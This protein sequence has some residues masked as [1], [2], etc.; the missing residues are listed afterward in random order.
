[1]METIQQG[2][3][4][5]GKRWAML[6]ALVSGLLFPLASILIITVLEQVLFTF[7]NIFRIHLEH[8]ELF[9]LY[10]LPLILAYIVHLFYA[11]L[12]KKQEYFQHIIRRKDETINRNAQFAEEIGKGYY[13]VNIIPDGDEDVLGKSLLAM[14]ENLLAKDRKESLHNWISEG[15]DL[16]SNILRIYNKLEEIGDHLLEHLTKY[17]DAVQGAIYLYHEEEDSLIS[18]SAYAYQHKNNPGQKFKVGYGLIG[19]CAYERKYIYR[20]EIPDDYF[21]ISSGLLG[22]KKP[23]SLLI[24][25]LITEDMLQGVVEM[26]FLKP[27]IPEQTIELMKELGEIIA[28]AILNLRINQKTEKLLLELENSHRRFYW[29]LEN[30]SEIITIYNRD[31]NITFVSPSVLR[32]LGYSQKE[33][34]N[35]KDLEGIGKED[36]KRMKELFGL[37]IKDPGI[38]PTMQYQYVRKDDQQVTLESKFMNRLEDP[39]VNGIILNIID[40]TGRIRTEKE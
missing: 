5:P 1:M 6:I 12:Q 20:T 31:L 10:L 19:Q 34:M 28:R 18:L 25:P 2:S 33:Y 26:A 23:A 15:R 24:L 38:T 27:E 40:I 30:T 16:I 22:E 29:L 32:I 35:G 13:N 17:T 11:R 36:Q 4:F 8:P 3:D 9:I 7:K 14:K 21:T 37:I 39:S